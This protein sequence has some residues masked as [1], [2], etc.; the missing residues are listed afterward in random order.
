M[1]LV[2]LTQSPVVGSKKPGAQNIQDVRQQAAYRSSNL[3]PFYR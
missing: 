1:A 2:S 3:G